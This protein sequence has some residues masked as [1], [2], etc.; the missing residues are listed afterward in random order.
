MKDLIPKE[1]LTRNLL[2]HP[3]VGAWSDLNP[4]RVEPEQIETLRRASKSS[5][6][7]LQK[8]GPGGS[9]VIAKRCLAASASIECLVYQDVLPLLPLPALQCYGVVQDDEPEFRW[10]FLED[11]GIQPYLKSL[12][13][14]R[15]LLAE[16]LAAVHSLEF[17]KHV[18]ERLPDRGPSHYLKVLGSATG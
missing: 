1:I 5:I 17:D 7:R 18:T 6:Y 2:E 9:N 11:A 14:H 3:A 12:P 10:L 16:W 4:E 13:A 8:A 15:A